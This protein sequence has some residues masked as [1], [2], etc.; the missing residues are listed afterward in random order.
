M[1]RVAYWLCE[2]SGVSYF[3]KPQCL[4]LRNGNSHSAHFI[5]F[6][7]GL[8][9]CAW[10]EPSSEASPQEGLCDHELPSVSLPWGSHA[11]FPGERGAYVHL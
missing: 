11:F 4:H 1:L 10:K 6:Q 2:P 9:D 7:G 8:K 5:E 3:S